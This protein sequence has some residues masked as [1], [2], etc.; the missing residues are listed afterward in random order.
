VAQ[1]FS[2]P[3]L[4][5]RWTGRAPKA[6]LWFT[7]PA[8][9]G[10]PN[11]SNSKLNIGARVGTLGLVALST[12]TSLARPD[13]QWS[14]TFVATP[15]EVKELDMLRGALPSSGGRTVDPRNQMLRQMIMHRGAAYNALPFKAQ[16]HLNA[17]ARGAGSPEDYLGLSEEAYPSLRYSSGVNSYAIMN[18]APAGG[19]YRAML[20]QEM[21]KA[22]TASPMAVLDA[23]IAKGESLGGP[24]TAAKA[25]QQHRELVD[26][27]HG[28]EEAVKEK[29]PAAGAPGAK[30]SNET[31]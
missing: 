5:N 22:R 16:Q 25:E 12:S 14:A 27:V 24:A 26:A 18:E 23:A 9:A 31:F 8:F 13:G 10:V 30:T 2:P 4:K 6:R 20:L 17:I 29:K 15:N 21:S 11:R 7:T 19:E 1:P 3:P 28:V